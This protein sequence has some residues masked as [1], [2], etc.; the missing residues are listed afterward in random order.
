MFSAPVA[1]LAVLFVLDALSTIYIIGHGGRESN[2]VMVRLMGLLGTR[3]ALVITKV[4]A[5]ALVVFLA[6]A[7]GRWI[8]LAVALY[9]GVVGWNLR[10]IWLARA[11]SSGA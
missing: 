7:M 6:P 3:G 1:A 9:V 10:Q 2:P 5:L 11:R 8:W 4:A